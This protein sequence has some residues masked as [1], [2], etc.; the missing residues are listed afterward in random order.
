MRNYRII[1]D[2]ILELASVIDPDGDIVKKFKPAPLIKSPRRR[3]SVQNKSERSDYSQKYMQKYRD[4]G[5]DY[6][7]IPDGL[8]EFRRKQKESLK[9]KFKD[10]Q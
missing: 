5:K 6:Q 4:E 3:P 10:K 9:E 1:S 7:K 8:K 2:C